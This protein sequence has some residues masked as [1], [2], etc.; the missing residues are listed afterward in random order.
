MT[1]IVLKDFVSCCLKKFFCGIFFKKCIYWSYEDFS[2]SC[3]HAPVMS[4]AWGY[5]KFSD[6]EALKN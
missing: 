1:D 5:L 4:P 2:K 3:D 6:F